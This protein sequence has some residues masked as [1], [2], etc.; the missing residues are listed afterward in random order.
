MRNNISSPRWVLSCILSVDFIYFFLNVN[1]NIIKLLWLLED[2]NMSF[3]ISDTH[4]STLPT[5]APCS[6]PENAPGCAAKPLFKGIHASFQFRC[7]PKTWVGI[8]ATYQCQCPSG[9][10]CATNYTTIGSTSYCADSRH[11]KCTR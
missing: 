5:Y 10:T 3:C 6:W 4:Q 2:I 9:N 11:F 8:N 1:F 7:C